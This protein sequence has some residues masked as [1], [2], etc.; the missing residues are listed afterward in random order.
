MVRDKS[1]GQAQLSNYPTIPL[2]P[3]RFHLQCCAAES[4]KAAVSLASLHMLAAQEAHSKTAVTTLLRLLRRLKQ[5]QKQKT[6][7]PC[8]SIGLSSLA[9]AR[10]EGNT[11][12]LSSDLHST[13]V[14]W[15]APFTRALVQTHTLTQ[16]H[17]YA[18]THTIIINKI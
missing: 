17:T 8:K 4:A 11:G 13:R 10:V 1:R 7:S 15:H 16:T 18:H 3:P 14:L 6:R 2:S 12:S 9:R 5:K